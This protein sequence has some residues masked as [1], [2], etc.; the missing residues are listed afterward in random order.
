[1]GEDLTGTL[2]R[3]ASDIAHIQVADVPGRGAPGTGQL[4][5]E[6]LFRQLAAQGYE[7]WIGCEYQASDPA[8]SATSFS[9]MR[10][11]PLGESD[12]I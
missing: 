9:W 1:M 3:Y 11:R 6:A 10:P 8:A 7:G 2:A 4:D 12:E 5:Y